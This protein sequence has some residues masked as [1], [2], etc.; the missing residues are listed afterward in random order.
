MGK[1]YKCIVSIIKQT[2]S[3]MSKHIMI[4]NLKTDIKKRV[5][6]NNP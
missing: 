4:K 2:P 3:N 5:L 6:K 1:R